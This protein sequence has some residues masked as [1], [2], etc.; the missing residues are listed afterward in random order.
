MNEICESEAQ[1]EVNQTT[2]RVTT[3]VFLDIT[4]VVLMTEKTI[5]KYLSKVIKSR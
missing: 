2:N 1:S 5:V 3:Q 4:D